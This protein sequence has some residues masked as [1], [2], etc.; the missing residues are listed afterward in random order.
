MG[1]NPTPSAKAIDIIEI[2]ATFASYAQS[3]VQWLLVVGAVLFVLL[4]VS[5]FAAVVTTVAKIEAYRE[6]NGDDLAP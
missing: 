3:A 4:L 6:R 2:L 1:S 5:G